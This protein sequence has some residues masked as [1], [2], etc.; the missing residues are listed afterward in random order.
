MNPDGQRDGSGWLSFWRGRPGNVES[1]R[2]TGYE[3]KARFV[4]PRTLDS[5]NAPKKIEDAD[6]DCDSVCA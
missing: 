1:S 6:I 3:A 4:N 5:Q 2:R